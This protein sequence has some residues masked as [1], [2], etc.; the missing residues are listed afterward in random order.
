[1]KYWQPNMNNAHM[2][3]AHKD[4]AIR[5][6]AFAPTDVKFATA[7]DDGTARVWDF[8]R[9]SEER[10]LRGHGA[11]V[12]CIDWHPT[13]GLLVTGSR[14]TQQ[15]VKIWD[16]KTG[17]CLATLQEHKSS[18]M[19]V[20]FNKNGNWLLTGGRDHL[21]KLYDIRMMKEVKTFRAHKKEV[22][23]EF[24]EGHLDMTDI[25]ASGRPGRE[26]FGHP[27]LLTDR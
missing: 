12:R 18:V 3:S 2:F 20:E 26:T 6:L 25:Q 14:D 19:A 10:V 4:E 9:Y 7:S 17:S 16:P 13:K 1:M 27:D 21:V 23:C 5:G 15:P 8:A 11:E 22:I 24:E